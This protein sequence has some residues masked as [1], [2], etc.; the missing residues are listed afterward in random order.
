VIGAIIA[1]LLC[2]GAA[3][4]AASA[5]DRAIKRAAGR[6]SGAVRD[7]GRELQER[8]ETVAPPCARGR[9]PHQRVSLDYYGDGS[10]A[11][12]CRKCGEQLE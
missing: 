5:G 12:A 3:L 11:Y 4:G 2:G 6:A 8:I 1:G 10:P 9:A 7:A